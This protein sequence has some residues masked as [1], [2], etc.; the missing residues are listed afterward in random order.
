MKPDYEAIIV[1]A[2]FGG[3][4]AAIQLQRL[5]IDKIL[6]LERADDL[7]G[8]WHLNTYPGLAVDIVSLSYS[9][10]FE[11]NPNWSRLYAPGAELKA[12]ARHV[13]QK[14][15]LRRYM[16]FGA[17][18]ERAQYDEALGLWRVHPAGQSP[19]TARLLI[20]ATGFLSQPKRPDIPGV[21]TFA[22]KVIHTAEWDHAFDLAGRRAAMIG[23]GASAVQVLPKIADKV[24]HLDV[25]QRTPIWVLPRTNP[26]IPA[27]LQKVF[28]RVPLVQRCFRWLSDTVLELVMVTGVLHNRQMPF[29]T[30][31]VERG[32]RR[33]LASQ[34]KDPEL[35]RK[36]TPDY[37]FGCKRPTFS[38]RY[39]KTFTRASV[40]LVTTPIARIEPDAIVT[41]DGQ[42]REIDTLVLATGFN[43]WQK[44]N[45]PAFDVV[46]LGG[47]ELGE[48]W[49]RNH[50][51]SYEGITVP[52]FPNLFNIHS[53]YSYSGF[54]YFN[55]IEI[56][57][58]HMDRCLKE[59]RRRGAA[60]FEPTAEAQERF[61]QRMRSRAADTVFSAGQC[62]TSNSYYFNQHGEATLLRLSSTL[63]AVR[64]ARSF[65]L[66][67]YRF[68]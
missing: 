6:M 15:D 27:W 22:G 2:G 28:A 64:R 23:T 8:T 55:T 58:R 21:D 68:A 46:G 33:F 54:C 35:R 14:Y 59:M 17:S 60:T 47:A 44:G 4:G 11:P 65:P 40:E 9:Y 56:Q 67:D 63:A 3:M 61:M 18:V 45:F 30:R 10:S 1:G 48:L 39:F 5:G 24:A 66:E 16:R 38:N 62:A 41:A 32:A 19:L 49:N 29:L 20:L 25:Y 42:R 13:A 37:S 34:V 7:G 43:L 50:Y 26:R 51:Q 12:Y 52:G 53:P 31:M 36:L 57:M